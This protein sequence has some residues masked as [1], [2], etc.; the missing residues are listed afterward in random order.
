MVLQKAPVIYFTSNN[1]TEGV[2][3]IF[4]LLVIPV[5]KEAFFMA[6]SM[7]YLC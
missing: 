5:D 4:K 6:Y 7:A 1:D 3:N 2:S